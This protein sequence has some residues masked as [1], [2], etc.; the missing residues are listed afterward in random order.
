MSDE[1]PLS[2]RA[3]AKEVGVSYTAIQKAIA[4]GRLRECVTYDSKNRPKILLAKGREEWGEVHKGKLGV[5]VGPGGAASDGNEEQE[6]RADALKEK[7]GTSYAKSRAVRENYQA[8]IAKLTYEEKAGKLVKVDDVS[9]EAFE[10]A[11]TVRNSVLN[12]PNRLSALLANESDP[13]RVFEIL[14][15]E[16]N[17]ALEDLSDAIRRG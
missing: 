4:N 8:N 9:R 6:D 13:N 16:L 12:I 1:K 7:I 3:F 14:T 10:I 11:R 17:H 2:V 5:E 15:K